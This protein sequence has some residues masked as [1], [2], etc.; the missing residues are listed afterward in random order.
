MM[1]LM[2]A[3]E[4]ISQ[5]VIDLRHQNYFVAAF[6]GMICCFGLSTTLV[7]IYTEMTNA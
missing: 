3:G 6:M 7:F 4:V 1:A 5:N 2:L